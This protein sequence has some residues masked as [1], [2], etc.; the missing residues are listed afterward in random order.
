MFW[1]NINFTL[2]RF[3]DLGPYNISSSDQKSSCLCD[4]HASLWQEAGLSLPEAANKLAIG[5]MGKPQRYTGKFVSNVQYDCTLSW[6][7]GADSKVSMLGDSPLVKLHNSR[8]AYEKSIKA[9]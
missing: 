5:K 8:A 7:G 4:P 1:N 6:S 9:G 2:L 3:D